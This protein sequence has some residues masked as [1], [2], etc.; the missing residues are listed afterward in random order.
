MKLISLKVSHLFGIRRAEFDFTPS[1]LISIVGKNGSGKSSIMDSLF[2][3]LMGHAT[4]SRGVKTEDYI[5]RGADVGSVEL[6]FEDLN[7]TKRR[8]R[9]KLSLKARSSGINHQAELA[10]YDDSVNAWVNES[11]ML[12]DVLYK[13]ASILLKGKIE[14][15]SQSELKA[16]VKQAETALSIA[17]FISQGNIV[18]IL[19]VTPAERMQL[20]TS[21]FNISGSDKLKTEAKELKKIADKE[22]LTIESSRKTMSQQLDNFGDRATLEKDKNDAEKDAKKYGELKNKYYELYTAL[23][24]Y[25]RLYDD[26]SKAVEKAN[27]SKDMYIAAKNYESAKASAASHKEYL[28]AAEKLKKTVSEL[29][30]LEHRLSEMS[31]REAGVQMAYNDAVKNRKAV[32]EKYEEAESISAYAKDYRKKNELEKN[33]SA[34]EREKESA[35]GQ[36]R[37][38]ETKIKK[39]RSE[40][41]KLKFLTAI[42][43]YSIVCQ[44]LEALRKA[45]FG[46]DKAEN[47]YLAAEKLASAFSKLK[48][49]KNLSDAVAKLTKERDAKKEKLAEIRTAL[50]AANEMVETNTKAAAQKD[51]AG[52]ADT[53]K[54]AASELDVIEKK[55][56]ETLVQLLYEFSDD[57]II[58]LKDMSLD[59]DK[60]AKWASSFEHSEFKTLVQQSGTLKSTMTEAK[61]QIAQLEQEYPYLAEGKFIVVPEATAAQLRAEAQKQTLAAAKM[62]TEISTLEKD[63]EAL[64][65][66][67]SESERALSSV[68]EEV[69][70]IDH[71][72]VRNAEESRTALKIAFDETNKKYMK[73]SAEASGADQKKTE[74]E[75]L[76]QGIASEHD[77]STKTLE[78][79]KSESSAKNLDIV[80]LETSNTNLERNIAN[81]KTKIV[82]AKEE[83]NTVLTALPD[84]ITEEAALKAEKERGDLR[85]KLNAA[86]KELYSAKESLLKYNNELSKTKEDI[87]RKQAELISVKADAK[88]KSWERFNTITTY[89][90]ANNLTVQ[91]AI[92]NAENAKAPA[93]YV[94]LEAAKENYNKDCGSRESARQRLEHQKEDTRKLLDAYN[95]GLPVTIDRSDPKKSSSVAYEMSV[96]YDE[97]AK[98]AIASV[99]ALTERIEQYDK[100]QAL[101]KEKEKELE[102]IEPLR[103]YA[104]TI[105]QMSDGNN[106]MRFMSDT[107]MAMLLGGVNSYLE[108]IGETWK[109]ASKDGELYVQGEEGT[110]RPVSGMSGG[111]Q[112]LISVLLLKHISNFGCLWLD[113]SLPNLDEGRLK[114]TVD[115]LTAE[116]STQM[117]L[118]THDPD[119]AR[120]FPLTWTMEDGTLQVQNDMSLD[121]SFEEQKEDIML[122]TGAEL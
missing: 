65:A 1:R 17:A 92:H 117:L 23:S 47:E 69:K 63:C 84:N 78:E 14:D 88:E 52:A 120:L 30:T 43:E 39:Y 40:A 105:A 107:A 11:D 56:V 87:S 97:Q 45:E 35:E 27:A 89:A 86:D 7:G 3:A 74:L 50:K 85:I 73:A 36:I 9:R 46:K 82:G 55:L 12:S 95:S 24:N 19:S 31:Q 42:K 70:G 48:E 75:D 68:A 37:D 62:E 57:G 79:L 113:E 18:K 81:L 64:N 111:E 41:E 2:F 44:K 67:I 119:L 15:G 49:Y 103:K 6:I 109:V 66:N 33:I 26:L 101:Y 16:L 53:H 118:T 25:I 61:K 115:I 20:I 60:A 110:P 112:V 4:A 80:R 106:F 28:A 116:N 8:I 93:G 38:N 121:A 10:T 5:R 32:T 100:T 114:E 29:I 58:N 77:E 59:S 34:A 72:A 102:K 54:K 83:L 122:Q 90:E 21:A 98:S 99:S 104:H 51:Y 71:D 94:S 13:V 96:K 76:Y 108:R 22:Y 91:Q